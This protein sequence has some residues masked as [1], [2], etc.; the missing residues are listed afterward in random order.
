MTPHCIHK[1][2][3]RAAMME[4]PCEVNP[5][6]L[7]EILGIKSSLNIQQY[8]QPSFKTKEVKAEWN[9]KLRNSLVKA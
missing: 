6:E 5:E 1:I 9:K 8:C 3:P 7:S 2:G 4:L